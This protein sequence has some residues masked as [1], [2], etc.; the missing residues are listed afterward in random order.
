MSE[1]KMAEVRHFEHCLKGAVP[2]VF[3]G[4]KGVPGDAIFAEIEVQGVRF[5]VS[6]VSC[7][8]DN[9]SPEQFELAL[10]ST[11]AALAKEV[12][13]TLDEGVECFGPSE[14]N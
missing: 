12:G 8:G 10:R 13:A 1:V 5:A 11:I 2:A 9:C 4:G 6:C 14:V 3:K 7:G